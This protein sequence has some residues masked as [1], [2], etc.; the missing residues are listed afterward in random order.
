MLRD[1]HVGIL[2]TNATELIVFA[3]GDKDCTRSVSTMVVCSTSCYGYRFESCTD[4]KLKSNIQMRITN[5]KIG[6][7]AK[8]ILAFLL[9]FLWFLGCNAQVKPVNKKPIPVNDT[10]SL[11]NTLNDWGFPSDASMLRNDKDPEGNKTKVT[12]FR[13][14]STT[15][16]YKPGQLIYLKGKCII[17]VKADGRLMIIP[18]PEYEGVIRLSYVVNDYFAGV[19][20]RGKVLIY[21]WDSEI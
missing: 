3:I 1:V 4:H 20:K 12:S 13:I 2:K 9:A 15:V 11:P 8:A 17:T 7:F 14:D 18:F 10:I 6:V 21:I 5:I 16:D 19:G